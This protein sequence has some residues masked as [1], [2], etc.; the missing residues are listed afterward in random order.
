MCNNGAA[1]RRIYDLPHE[2]QGLVKLCLQAQAWGCR[3]NVSSYVGKPLWLRD[4]VLLTWLFLP[5]TLLTG[6]QSCWIRDPPLWSHLA[7]ILSSKALSP[8]TV[9]VIMRV[10]LQ[11][12]T[13]GGGGES[14]ET[15]R[16]QFLTT[17]VL[18]I[19]YR[20][21]CLLC[22]SKPQHT[23]RASLKEQEMCI[24]GVTMDARCRGEWGNNIIWSC[25]HTLHYRRDTPF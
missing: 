23:N 25:M 17:S 24:S 18:P 4:R 11:Q 1:E 7:L 5:A 8:K 20:K 22:E 15:H 16:I 6:T 2:K 13:W 19:L 12:I 3:M 14:G 21:I 9:I 10:G